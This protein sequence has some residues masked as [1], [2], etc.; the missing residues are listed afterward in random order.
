MKPL[1]RKLVEILDAVPDAIFI[2]DPKTTNVLHVNL[3]AVGMYGYSLDEFLRLKAPDLSTHPEATAAF[4]RGV[5]N[6]TERIVPLRYH[7]KKDGAIFPVEIAARPVDLDGRRVLIGAI[8][9]VSRR[10]GAEKKLEQSEGRYA[11]LFQA[12]LQ[13]IMA[14]NAEGLITLANPAAARMLGYDSPDEFAGMK[15]ER[16][17]YDRQARESLLLAI[18][19]KRVSFPREAVLKRKDGN[20]LPVLLSAVAEMDSAGNYLG[21]VGFFVDITE[22]KRAETILRFEKERLNL[23]AHSLGASLVVISRGRQIVWANS[24]ARETF[25]EIEGGPLPPRLLRPGRS[26]RPLHRLGGVR[27]P[28]PESRGEGAGGELQGRGDV[29]A[30]RAD[31]DRRP[32]RGLRRRPQDDPPFG[33]ERDRSAATFG[34]Q[35]NPRNQ[36]SRAGANQERIRRSPGGRR[37]GLEVG[38]TLDDL[39]GNRRVPLRQARHGL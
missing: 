37:R 23:V 21:A 15:S 19:E 25:G 20:P 38:G 28:I 5:A 29:R 39:A 18:K 12:S 1:D 22:Q 14:S 6:G 9:D 8:R 7:R 36:A 10:V 17:W 16:V 2:V 24:L 13:G 26:L 3:T 4:L 33:P 31:K 32:R 30:S 11:T 35:E 34:H 27:R